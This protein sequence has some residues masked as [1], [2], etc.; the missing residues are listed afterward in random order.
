[1]VWASCHT[2]RNAASTRLTFLISLARTVGGGGHGLCQ[3]PPATATPLQQLVVPQMMT[4]ES[5]VFISPDE[6]GIPLA[7]VVPTVHLMLNYPS[8]PTVR[9]A[10]T[11]DCV[12]EILFRFL[13]QSGTK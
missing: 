7:F 13:R 8:D 3:G 5:R 2:L 1:M 12:F 10:L 9:C 4:G 11:G 6:A